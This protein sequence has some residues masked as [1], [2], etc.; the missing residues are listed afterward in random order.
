MKAIVLKSTE[1]D[2]DKCAQM[3]CD[4]E[5]E[6]WQDENVRKHVLAS[7]EK[8]VTEEKIRVYMFNLAFYTLYMPIDK[9]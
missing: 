2:M 8:P 6:L 3:I 1:M 4:R 5:V 7:I 9:R